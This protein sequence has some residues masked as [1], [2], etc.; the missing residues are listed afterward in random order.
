MKRC[1]RSVAATSLVIE[2]ED[3]LVATSPAGFSVAAEVLEDLDL[4]L[5]VLGRGLDL[6]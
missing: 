5:L 2:I 3:V 1:G 6:V 4:Q